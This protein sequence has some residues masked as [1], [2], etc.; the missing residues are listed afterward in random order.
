MT[1]DES[2]R[3]ILY[4]KVFID[5]STLSIYYPMSNL[6]AISY[7][8]SGIFRITVRWWRGGGVGDKMKEFWFTISEST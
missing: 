5:S 4:L 7:S 1:K 2:E 8:D 6:K 3:N